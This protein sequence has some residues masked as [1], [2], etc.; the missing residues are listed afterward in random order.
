MIVRGRTP[1]EYGYTPITE[2]DGRNAS[3]LMDFGILC[4]RAGERW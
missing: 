1:F 3:M 2:I 4:L